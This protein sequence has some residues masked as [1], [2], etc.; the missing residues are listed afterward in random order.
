MGVQRQV[1][2]LEL[3]KVRK[4]SELIEFRSKTLTGK[5]KVLKALKVKLD[6]QPARN[7]SKGN[8]LLTTNE[9]KT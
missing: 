1:F 4:K 3:D 5:S 6:E 7:K 2:Q 8:K 9:I